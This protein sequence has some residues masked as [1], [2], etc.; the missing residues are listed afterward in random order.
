MARF[1]AILSLVKEAPVTDE[2]ELGD[3]GLGPGGP[4]VVP[5]GA[6]LVHLPGWLE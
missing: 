5:A 1:E 2:V 6:D 3:G 4:V